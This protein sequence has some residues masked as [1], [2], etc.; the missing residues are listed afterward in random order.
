MWRSWGLGWLVYPRGSLFWLSP[1]LV[2]WDGFRAG[3]NL[4]ALLRE[5]DGSLRAAHL[6]DQTAVLPAPGLVFSWRSWLSLL[7]GP[8]LALED[9]RPYTLWKDVFVSQEN[10]HPWLMAGSESREGGR[11]MSFTMWLGWCNIWVT[12]AALEECGHF[13]AKKEKKRKMV[14]VF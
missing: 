7:H 8:R 5:A 13:F 1:G 4:R 10:C 14:R 9:G 6:T 11:L 2:K 3:G 12:F